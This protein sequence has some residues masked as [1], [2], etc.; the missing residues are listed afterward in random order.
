VVVCLA[1]VQAAHLPRELMPALGCSQSAGP[2]AIV[3]AYCQASRLSDRC[4][5][6]TRRS[7][8]SLVSVYIWTCCAGVAEPADAQDLGT[9]GVVTV[10]RLFLWESL[11]YQVQLKAVLK[12][13]GV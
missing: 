8:G 2:L 9:R 7:K 11:R 6:Q 1:R 12:R 13:S 3:P 10:P 4:R 5:R